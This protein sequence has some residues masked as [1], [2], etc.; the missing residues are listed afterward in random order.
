MVSSD[1]NPA[2]Y[3]FLVSIIGKWMNE[4]G[5]L[6]EG[7]GQGNL[8]IPRDKPVPVLL[9]PL[10]LCKT[11][12]SAVTG[13]WLTAWT[14]TQPL[15]YV[16]LECTEVIKSWHVCYVSA[17]YADCSNQWNSPLQIRT[18]LNTKQEIRHVF[19]VAEGHWYSASPDARVG[20]YLPLRLTYSRSAT[21]N[22]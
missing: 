15:C 7:K 3:E 9:C 14:M 8:E 21:I 4:Y 17:W 6:V 11:R 5:S 16:V 20:H 10:P 1:N 19:W 2:W 12:A 18:L 22:A 13:R